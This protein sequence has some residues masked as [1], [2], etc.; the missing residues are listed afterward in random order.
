MKLCSE[1]KIE[2]PLDQFFRDKGFKDG[3]YSR[4]KQCKT[5]KTMQWR[6]LNKDK[7]NERARFYNKKHYGKLRLNRYDITE[8][9]YLAMLEKQ[10]HR[11]AIPSC[12]KTAT[13][14]RKL[15]LDHCHTTGKVRGL[16][17]Y[18]CNREMAIVDRP[19]KLLELIAYKNK[20]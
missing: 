16:L 2:K 6:E 11:C 17:C 15:C 3:Y 8:Q 12:R 19:D 10:N 14:K 9:E 18:G 13:I 4:C 7:Y 5:A 20:S 1:C